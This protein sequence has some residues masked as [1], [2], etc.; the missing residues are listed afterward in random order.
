MVI[1]RS[2]VLK[3]INQI[4]EGRDYSEIIKEFAVTDSVLSAIEENREAILQG[5]VYHKYFIIKLR[6]LIL[7]SYLVK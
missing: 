4:E 5:Y 1:K 2:S 7:S 3:I 6:N